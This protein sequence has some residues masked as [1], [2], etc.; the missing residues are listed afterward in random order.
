LAAVLF[1]FDGNRELLAE[2]YSNLNKKRRRYGKQNG[3]ERNKEARDVTQDLA[4][5]NLLFS[6]E[7]RTHK[8][9]ENVGVEKVQ[10]V[11]ERRGGNNRTVIQHP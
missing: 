9:R 8:K 5:V 4:A 11:S 3:E 2:M 6:N 10:E 1:L 7:Q